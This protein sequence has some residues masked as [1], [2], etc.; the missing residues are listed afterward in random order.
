[1]NFRICLARPAAL[2]LPAIAILA[3]GSPAFAHNN[4][5]PTPAR[6][7]VCVDH[8]LADSDLGNAEVLASE[9]F[10]RAGV[11][12][13]WRDR[14]GPCRGV[15]SAIVVDLLST[16][17]KSASKT[18]LAAANVSDDVHIEVFLDRIPSEFP[19][20]RPTA[21]AHVLVH[22]ITHILQGVARHSE[23][24]VMKAV[25]TLDDYDEMR[26][27]PLAFAPEDLELIR[28]GLAA[29]AARHSAALQIAA[30]AGVQT[31]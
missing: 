12:L 2:A 3:A 25:W 6:V 18:A 28:T 8:A 26:H 24:G 11:K 22:E 10:V 7:L 23:T 15:D 16:A 27:R 1:M 14:P 9:M 13:D 31:R 20:L 29:R 30:A 21:L 19:G 17:P 4:L 5:V